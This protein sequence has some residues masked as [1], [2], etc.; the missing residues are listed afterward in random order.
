MGDV[1]VETTPQFT[2]TLAGDTDPFLTPFDFS[3]V[4]LT[5]RP[6][7]IQRSPPLNPSAVSVGEGIPWTPKGTAHIATLSNVSVSERIKSQSPNMTTAGNTA[8]SR[9]GGGSPMEVDS[10]PSIRYDNRYLDNFISPQPSRAPVSTSPDSEMGSVYMP[11]MTTSLP[12][13][14]QQ[15]QFLDITPVPFNLSV[16]QPSQHDQ[17]VAMLP[18]PSPITPSIVEPPIEPQTELTI[19]PG[20]E[21]AVFRKAYDALDSALIT[22]SRTVAPFLGENVPTKQQVI[23][24]IP[25]ISERLIYGLRTSKRQYW[26][27]EFYLSP[28]H[29]HVIK[30]ET[31]PKDPQMYGV[32][33]GMIDEFWGSTDGVH[34][35]Y[36][37]D[38]KMYV[39]CDSGEWDGRWR[40]YFVE[41]GWN[42]REFGIDFVLDDFAFRKPTWK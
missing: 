12:P 26:E 20:M 14:V 15:R 1:L 21:N 31:H 37:I 7:D 25:Y 23:L 4:R 41:G 5:T 22:W 19:A 28:Y 2:E 16:S 9:S 17:A 10:P 34:A 40:V 11:T 13:F 32:Y 24:D 8:A 36:G 30:L 18:H 38:G 6:Q 3:R 27:G 33:I 42:P 35:L 39:G 29:T